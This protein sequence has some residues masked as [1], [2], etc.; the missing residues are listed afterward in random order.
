M[1]HIFFRIIIIV[2]LLILKLFLVFLV[3]DSRVRYSTFELAE[4]FLVE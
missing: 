2:L 3:H 4:S 1:V